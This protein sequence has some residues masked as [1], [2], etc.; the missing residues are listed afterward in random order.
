MLCLS[1]VVDGYARLWGGIIH[2][3]ALDAKK[4]TI[5]VPDE[6]RYKERPLPFKTRRNRAAADQYRG[7]QSLAWFASNDFHICCLLSGADPDYVLRLLRR[8]GL[9]V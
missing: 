6:P 9:N 7:R 8:D 1:A 4:A 3:V 2:Q 5:E